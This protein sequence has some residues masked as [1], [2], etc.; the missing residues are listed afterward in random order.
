MY[1]EAEQNVMKRDSLK[2]DTF[3]KQ[4]H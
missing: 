3:R 4:G 1:L 2:E